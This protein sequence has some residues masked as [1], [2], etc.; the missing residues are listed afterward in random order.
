MGTLASGDGVGRVRSL[1][2]VVVPTPLSASAGEVRRLG[3][4]G[5]ERAGVDQ[6]HPA[7]GRLQAIA[8]PDGTHAHPKDASAADEFDAGAI[9]RAA[10]TLHE[11]ATDH[12]HTV[13]LLTGIS[14]ANG[15][16]FS[17]NP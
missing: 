9:A 7:I 13:K 5:V 6:E 17:L 10:D 11:F 14:I 16:L 3:L 15:R 1:G 12:S 8:V 2:G 4:I